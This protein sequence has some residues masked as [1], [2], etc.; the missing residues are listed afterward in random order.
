MTLYWRSWKG[1]HIFG[2]SGKSEL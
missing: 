1:C 2:L